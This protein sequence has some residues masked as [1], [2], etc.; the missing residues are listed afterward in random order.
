MKVQLCLLILLTLIA[1]ERYFPNSGILRINDLYSNDIARDGK[2]RFWKVDGNGWSTII[3]SNPVKN[4][5]VTNIKM[6]L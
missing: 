3:S 1:S 2:D 6:Y 4:N 5:G